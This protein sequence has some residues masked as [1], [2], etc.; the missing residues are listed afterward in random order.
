MENTT[1]NQPVIIERLS[2]L[3]L[4]LLRD[5]SI[6]KYRYQTNLSLFESILANLKDLTPL[7]TNESYTYLAIEQNRIIA[8]LALNSFNVKSST[9]FIREPLIIHNPINITL[10]KLKLELLTKA[11][12][13]IQK[14]PLNWLIKCMSTDT[15]LISILRELGFQPLN[16][17]LRWNLSNQIH[18]DFVNTATFKSINNIASSPLSNN[19][20][21]D[22]MRVDQTFDST[23][24][25]Q[26]KDLTAQDYY[27]KRQIKNPILFLTDYTNHICIAALIYVESSN[28]RK[29]LRLIRN[30]AVDLNLNDFVPTFLHSIT[31]LLLDTDLETL[32]NDTL[33]TKFLSEH[34]YVL[35][36]E[37]V[38]L[39]KSSWKRN[40]NQTIFKTRTTFDSVFEN[41]DPQRPPLPTPY[42]STY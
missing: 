17:Y 16:K 38:L 36:S 9:W 15:Q 35:E 10:R 39:G 28:D 8:V 3:H 23:L 20:V 19:N 5:I 14:P 18:N 27:R 31:N 22:V 42:S 7:I 32:L 6:N 29:L 2:L 40:D 1:A 11:I 4:P 21:Y 26:I 12:S 13:N 37:F 30:T 41:I 25:K 24:L 34:T 33:L